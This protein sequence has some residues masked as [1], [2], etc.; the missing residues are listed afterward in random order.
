MEIIEV[1]GYTEEEKVK[2]A[3]KYLI[4]KEIEQNGLKKDSLSI[5]D[6]AISEI[7]N[8]YTR[9]SGVRNLQ[10]N[11]AKI[12]R[13]TASSIVKGKKSKTRII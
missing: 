8:Y 10:R 3:R 1:S 4:P 5:G 13:K 12:C 7:I 9:E 11:I 2:I 6:G